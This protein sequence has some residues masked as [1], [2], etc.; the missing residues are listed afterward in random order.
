MLN[1]YFIIFEDTH[2]ILYQHFWQDD[3]LIDYRSSAVGKKWRSSFVYSLQHY[4]NGFLNFF[5][6]RLHKI[7]QNTGFTWPVFSGIRTESVSLFFLSLYREI[8]IR[9]NPYSDMFYAVITKRYLA[10]ALILDS[11]FSLSI[12]NFNTLT[13]TLLSSNL[14]EGLSKA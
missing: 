2:F 11:I 3:G 6:N 4:R 10:V 5:N 8:Q 7:C 1:T 9:E 12:Q 14:S 13:V